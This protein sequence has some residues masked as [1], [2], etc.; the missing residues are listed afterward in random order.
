MNLERESESERDVVSE[1]GGSG[2]NAELGR[3]EPQLCRTS[4]C[5]SWAGML[6]PPSG[7]SSPAASVSLW[8]RRSSRALYVPDLQ[9][10]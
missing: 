2:R 6:G 5:V 10:S 8:E 3:G 4:E 1:T 7:M 9:S